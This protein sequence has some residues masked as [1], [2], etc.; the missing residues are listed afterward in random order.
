MR[1]LNRTGLALS[2]KKTRPA[3]Q[4]ARHDEGGTMG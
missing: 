1:R 4:Q 3:A 2:M